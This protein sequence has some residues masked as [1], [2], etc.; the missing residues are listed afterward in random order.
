MAHTLDRLETHLSDRY[1]IEEGSGAARL[2][3]ARA[4]ARPEFVV[5]EVESD[6]A[7]RVGSRARLFSAAEFVTAPPHANYDVAPDGSGFVMVR[8]R[9]A[10]GFQVV[11]NWPRR[12]GRRW[13]TDLDLRSC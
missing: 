3:A 11:L 4:A 6:P 9:R 13:G 10:Q 2:T 7:F 8:S 12:C 5:A 1:G